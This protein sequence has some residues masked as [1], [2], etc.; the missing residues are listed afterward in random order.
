M[1]WEYSLFN[2]GAKQTRGKVFKF[3]RVKTTVEFIQVI[4]LSETFSPTTKNKSGTQVT[5]ASSC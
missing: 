5:I 1:T 2:A 3:R 4:I